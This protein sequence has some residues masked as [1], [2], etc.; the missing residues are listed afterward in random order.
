M[1]DDRTRRVYEDL[2]VRPVINAAGSLTMLGGSRLSPGVREAMDAANRYFVDMK[3]L[4]KESG[5]VIAGMMGCEAAMVT[6]GCA[7]A[8][9]L[10]AAACMTGKDIEKLE[11]LPDTIGM[12]HN[13][14]VQSLQRY[15]YDRC[16]TI[17]G[18]RIE[19]V[20]DKQG[21]TASQ[22]EASIDENT[23][24]VLC[25]APGDREGVVPIKEVISIATNKNVP[26]IVDAASEVYPHERMRRYTDMGADIV[27]FGAKYFGSC[28]STGLMC[29]R[30]ELV[31]AAF[32]HSFIS[33]ETEGHRAVGRP[34]KVDRQEVIATVTALREWIEM[35]HDARFAEADKR[36]RLIQDGLT[37]VKHIEVIPVTE[38]RGLGNGLNIRV[39]EGSLGKTIPQIIEELHQGDPDI[40]VWYGKSNLSVAVHPLTEEDAVIVRDRLREVLG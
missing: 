2:G 1:S 15:K 19:E 27:G 11:Q 13:F 18:G 21:T 5:K 26:V 14:L 40:W 29:G 36:T 16:M 22:L 24:A 35:D 8:L 9:S 32:L 30:K 34:M 39:D 3:T 37:E 6:P 33:F 23:A 7:S 4:L 17:F 31:D 28:N 12:K 38:E 25:V 10:G 20:G